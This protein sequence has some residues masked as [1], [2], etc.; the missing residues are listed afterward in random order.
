LILAG[1]NR[2]IEYDDKLGLWG[3]VGTDHLATA[4]QPWR[5][6]AATN[7]GPEDRVLD[8]GGHIGSFTKFCHDRCAKSITVVEAAPDNFEVLELNVGSLDGVTVMNR[9]VVGDGHVGETVSFYL[10][11]GHEKNGSCM[12]SL[13]PLRGRREITVQ[14][15]RLSDLIRTVMPTIIKCD[16]EGSEYGLD[17]RGLPECVRSIGMEI[18]FTRD[19]YRDVQAPALIKTLTDQGFAAIAGDRVIME[20]VPR[21]GTKW[22]ACAVFSR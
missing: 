19:E 6:F 16:V 1:S 22:G 3:A 13:V 5:E 18:H 21:F 20:R 7:P 17:F 11:R 12:G 14:A 2:E 8:L 9:A 15:V 4:K 10:T